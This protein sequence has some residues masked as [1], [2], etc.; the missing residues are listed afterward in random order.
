MTDYISVSIRRV[1]Q[2][3]F[4]GIGPSVPQITRDFRILRARE[5]PSTVSADGVGVTIETVERNAR[6]DLKLPDLKYEE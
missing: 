5:D 3:P 4:G 6:L 1:G 2:R